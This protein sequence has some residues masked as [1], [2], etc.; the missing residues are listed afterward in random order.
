MIFGIGNDIVEIARIRSS[1]EKI[2]QSFL[3]RIFSSVEQSYCRKFKDPF[4][5]LAAR[6]CAKEAVSKA[7][8]TGIGEALA[9]LDI[10]VTHNKKGQPFIILS[11]K[12]KIRFSNPKIHISLSHCK[13]YA[14]A[15]AIVS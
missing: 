3:D 1:V 6:F 5:S 9:F 4:P 7:L 12:A 10:E 14:M 8:G 13:E 11:E 15:V 2:G